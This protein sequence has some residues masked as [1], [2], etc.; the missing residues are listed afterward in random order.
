[1]LD[2]IFFTHV[3]SLLEEINV[4]T[5]EHKLENENYQVPKKK[6]KKQTNKQ[7]SSYYSGIL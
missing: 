1:M 7:N 3:F 6:D 4:Y 5:T 2:V